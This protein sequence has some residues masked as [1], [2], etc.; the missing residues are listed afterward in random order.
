MVSIIYVIIGLFMKSSLPPF[1]LLLLYGLSFFFLDV[2][3]NTTAFLLPSDTFEPEVRATLNGI[4]AAGGKVGAVLGIFHSWLLL[5][6]GTFVLPIIQDQY[7][8]SV[9]FLK[10]SSIYALDYVH[11]FRLFYSWLPSDLVLRS[12]WLS[13][14]HEEGKG[15]CPGA[16]DS[17]WNCS[18]SSL[19]LGYK[20]LFFFVVFLIEFILFWKAFVLLIIC[21][22]DLMWMRIVSFCLNR[23][24][25]WM[26]NLF[27]Y[28]QWWYL[29]LKSEN[30]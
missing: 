26:L 22:L 3:P 19:I 8:S 20:Y 21:E 11:L 2:G 6:L 4:S 9:V 24:I 7:G 10:W 28:F 23:Y 30:S 29:L 18:G 25:L 27:W 5:S 17:T 15:R 16:F 13:Q 12:Q 1:V 14:V